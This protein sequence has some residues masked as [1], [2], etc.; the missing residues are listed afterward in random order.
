MSSQVLTQGIGYGVVLGIGFVFALIMMGLSTLQ[1]RYTSYKIATSEEFNTASRSVKP[2]LIASGIVSAWTWAATLLQSSTVTYEYGLCGGYYYAAGATIQI[3]VMSIL[4]VRVKMIAPYCHTYLEIVHARYGNTAHFIF[5]TFGLV[6]NLIVSSMLLLGGSAVVNAFT[7]MNIYAANF[8][9]PL[10]VVIYVILGGLRATFLCDYSHTLILMIIILYFFFYTYAEADLIGGFDGMYRLLQQASAE[11]PVSGNQDGSYLTLKSNYGLMFMIIQITGGFGTV[12]LDQGYWQRAIA[13]EAKT[14]V[15]AYL[16]G[17]VAWFAVP[18][19]FSTIMGLSA[20]ALAN[21]PSFPYPG[22]LS[23][24]QT[25]AGLAAP[26]GVVA[27]LGSGGAAAMLILLFMAVTSAASSEMIATS[28]ILTFDLYQI[29]FKPDASPEALIR[30]SHVMVGIWAIIMSCVA[31]LWNGI[32]ISLNWLFLFSGTL[33]TGAVGPI[34]FSVV[35]RKQTRAAAI[36]GALGGLVVGITCWLVV[37]KTYYGE[38]TI[39]TTGNMY[40]NLAGNM[41]ACCSG[42][43]ISIIITLINPDNEFDWSETKK[44]NPRGRDL[45]KK[46]IVPG[47]PAALI[48]N[49]ANG[50]EPPTPIDEKKEKSQSTT[51]VSSIKE[52][53]SISEYPEDYEMLKKSLRVATWAT[54]I[55]TF[56]VIFL[57][58]IPMFLS[59]YI[60]SL[61]FFKAWVII[62]VIWLFVAAFITSV[63]PLWESRNAMSD[64]GRGLLKDTFGVGVK[65]ER[66]ST[67]A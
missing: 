50:E 54:S 1:N 53:T 29:H 11:R 67:S 30:V 42:A 55:M 61:T 8:L 21:H 41:G 36:G 15:R 31:S 46:R 52:D 56:I 45:D 12:M 34:I 32:G 10:G 20:V 2:G 39:E 40:P 18:L 60:F 16:L 13:S 49:G 26:A 3:F 33:F 62:C 44:I 38:V 6:T 48:A 25:D 65:K 22:G 24:A 47:G 7:G 51:R 35:W 28:S 66:S 43:L 64:I 58:P 19:T 37:A 9:I 27:L 4:S 23:L 5:A 59:H 14:A 63:L 57:I 17:G